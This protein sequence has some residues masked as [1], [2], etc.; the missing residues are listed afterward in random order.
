[1]VWDVIICYCYWGG[2]QGACVSFLVG[3]ALCILFFC[4]GDGVLL[5]WDGSFKSLGCHHLILLRGR[6][7]LGVFWWS[8]IP[9]AGGRMLGQ[10]LGRGALGK[11]FLWG[12]VVD[13]E[14][15]K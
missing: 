4:M 13:S 3:I 1:M 15:C 11:V 2:I 9:L 7:S 14:G 5:A 8:S 6:V 10:G 12:R